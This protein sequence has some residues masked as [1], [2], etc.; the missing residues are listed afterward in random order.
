MNVPEIDW[1][2]T[3][4]IAYPRG[5]CAGVDRAIDGLKRVQ[6]LNLDGTVYSYHDIIHNDHVAN[7]FRETGVQFIDNISPVPEGATLVFSAHGVSPQ[8][9]EQARRHN[10]KTFDLTCPLVEKTHREAIRWVKEGCTI[11]YIGH[12]G[13]DEA[14]GTLGEIPLSKQ[15]LIE[16]V[17][18]AQNVQ[19]E[20]PKK[21]AMI[22][23]TTLSQDETARIRQIL[24]KRYPEIVEPSSEDICYA[25]QHR[26]DGVKLLIRQGAEIVVAFGSKTSSN[27]RRLAEVARDLGVEAI[28]VNHV[29]ELSPEMF[30]G[31]RKVGLTSGA[32]APEDK[33]QEVV[34]FFRRNGTRIFEEVKVPGADESRIKFILP[35]ELR[36]NP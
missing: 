28:F 15:R 31:K 10:L 30:T 22:T 14:V 9:E 4:L 16:T 32:S 1:P 35:I 19:V 11:L 6:E 36:V 18:D 12:K 20:D 34:E 5:F 2:E 29:S 27:S 23:Q 26:Q 33:F 3:V 25:T 24:R 8:V 7:K 21:L 17:V 13:H